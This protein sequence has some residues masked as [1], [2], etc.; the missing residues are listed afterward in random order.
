ML[1]HRRRRI[2]NS[3]GGSG[4]LNDVR[5]LYYRELVS[6]FSHHLA[7]QWN[8]GEENNN[9]DFNRA[10][11]AEYIRDTD[12]YNHPIN[13]HTKWYNDYPAFYDG[14]LNNA[15]YLQYFEATSIQG[16]ANSYNDWAIDLRNDS[17]AAGR[18]WVV[19]GDEQGP[20]VDPAGNNN[21]IRKDAL[22][23]NLMGGGA[24]V[25]WYFGYQNTFGDIQSEDFAIVETLWEQTSYAINF[26]QDYLPFHE[27][28]PDN[29]L[30]SAGNG[31]L[32]FAKTGEYYVIYLRFG[33]GGGI[34][35]NIGDPGNYTGKMVQSTNRW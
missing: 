4:S 20:A 15:S 30:L 2:D 11:F 28:S 32:C 29:S 9:T 27:M 22:W 23:G 13:V 18:K 1:L 10:A 12:P 7:I 26:F 19:Y 5:K 33:G 21:G 34:D 24:G 25:E 16:Q 31:D 14:L 3:L 17:E 8:L 35:L 6:R